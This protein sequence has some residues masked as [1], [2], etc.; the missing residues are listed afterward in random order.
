MSRDADQPPAGEPPPG[1]A[2]KG[3]ANGRGKVFQA[4]GNLY[5]FE[6]RV[7][8][9]TI[10]ALAAA[11]IAAAVVVPSLLTGSPGTPVRATSPP[12]AGA[13]TRPPAVPA[14]KGLLDSSGLGGIGPSFMQTNLKLPLSSG[15]GLVVCGKEGTCP[16]SAPARAFSSGD[17]S[18]FLTEVIEDF[19]SLG[20]AENGYQAASGALAHWLSKSTDISS[21]VAGLGAKEQATDGYYSSAGQ[22]EPA[23][24]EAI[25]SGR[26][27]LILAE[28]T[29]LDRT[30]DR[31]SEFDLYA[32]AAVSKMQESLPGAA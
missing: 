7:A 23:Y 9:L 30:F 29:P 18:L 8:S 17:H 3:R 10:A 32:N 13:A 31:I 14:D 4:A 28:Q 15:G 2:L 21:E 6:N 27:V 24:V 22:T 11:V 12:P 1:T 16:T 26:Y 25:L 20:A 5:I 19:P